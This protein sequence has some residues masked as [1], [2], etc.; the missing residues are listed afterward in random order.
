MQQVHKT[1]LLI[2][3]STNAENVS[4][5]LISYLITILESEIKKRG[6]TLIAKEEP[7]E[8]SE[9]IKTW[10]EIYLLQCRIGLLWDFKLEI[11]TQQ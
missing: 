4:I 3:C 8:I 1:F 5:A 10:N 9:V 11:P 6:F 7:A 2:S